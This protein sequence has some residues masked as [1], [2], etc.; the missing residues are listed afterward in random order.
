M[1]REDR[2]DRP[3]DEL[4]RDL[5][6]EEEEATALREEALRRATPI[7]D[8]AIDEFFSG[9][10]FPREELFR[11]G[12]LGLMNAVH[13][14]DLAHGRPFREYAENLIK[15]EIRQHIRDRVRKTPIPGWMRD[16]NRQLEAAEARLLRGKG[17]L[18]TLSGL[19][20]AV[21]ITEDGIAEIFKARGALSYVS[22][23]AAQRKNDPVPEIDYSKIRSARPVPFPI[24]S[25]IKIASALER[26]AKLQQLLCQSLFRTE[27]A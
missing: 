8:A 16:L 12:Y 25:R 11:A 9:T 20:E 18:P 3:L 14:F 21:N 26:L 2:D 13:N 15:G 24:E 6:T 19:A 23:D 5:A 1:S 27:E 17:E 10:G 4:L 22:L 7:L